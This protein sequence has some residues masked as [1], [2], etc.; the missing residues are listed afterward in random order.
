MDENF[1]TEYYNYLMS[2][3]KSKITNEFDAEDI[4]SETF[5]R[6]LAYEKRGGIIKHYKTWLHNTMMNVINDLLRKKYKYPTVVQLDTAFDMPMEEDDDDFAEEEK[7][8]VRREVNYLSKITREVIILYYFTGL[9]V[10]RIAE[11]LEIPEGTV[12]SRL[13]SGRRQVKKGMENMAIQTIEKTNAIPGRLN[14]TT[15]GA[16]RMEMQSTVAN[17]LI[18]QN[19]LILAY[20]KPVTI[21]ELSRMISIPAAYIEP[22]V[23]RLCDMELMAKTE[24]G[25]VYTNFI[26]YN[27]KDAIERFPR[28]KKFAADNFDTIWTILEG[29]LDKVRAKEFYKALAPD[30]RVDLERHMLLKTL[31]LYFN[32]DNRLLDIKDDEEMPLHSDGCRWRAMG[33]HKP[34]D[35]DEELL[36]E[37]RIYEITGGL[38]TINCFGVRD[39]DKIELCMNEFDVRMFDNG[40]KVF[41]GGFN[42]YCNYMHRFLWSVWKDRDPAEDEIPMELINEID[43]FITSG[44]FERVDGKLKVLI[45]ILSKAEFDIFNGFIN[46][47]ISSLRESCNDKYRDFLKG[48]K[49][50]IP[51]H[52]TG[53]PETYRYGNTK[54]CIPMAVI[55]LAYEKG[56][57]LKGADHAFPPVIMVY[58]EHLENE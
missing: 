46:E 42:N 47:A 2:L 1:V 44:Y 19:L 40:G 49:M 23:D 34:A 56:L 8:A 57:H 20:D 38:R 24:S 52:L 37:V 25:K 18:M 12:K 11:Y 10:K 22:I 31:Q 48:G 7:A 45:P 43:S 33:F 50:S 35:V 5:I 29:M 17:D 15:S 16:V 54:D 6:A 58:D 21:S 36:D 39:N 26:I 55:R 51:E 53:I 41:I 4:V 30:S 9:E 28:Q 32:A 13:D 27:S 3:A 14:V